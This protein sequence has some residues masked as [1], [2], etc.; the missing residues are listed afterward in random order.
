MAGHPE[1]MPEKASENVLLVKGREKADQQ[2][3][4]SA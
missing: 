2:T 4:I 1:Q 3:G